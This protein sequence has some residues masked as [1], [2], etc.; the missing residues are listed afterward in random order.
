[1]TV[2]TVGPPPM[3]SQVRRRRTKTHCMRRSGGSMAPLTE[4]G[5]LFGLTSEKGTPG[6]TIILC[7]VRQHFRAPGN[8]FGQATILETPPRVRIDFRADDMLLLSDS[9]ERF[10]AM[11][12]RP[13]GEARSHE[14]I[15]LAV[16][17][18]SLCFSQMVSPPLP[19]QSCGQLCLTCLS[20]CCS[21][22]RNRADPQ[23]LRVVCFLRIGGHVEHQD[24]RGRGRPGRHTLP[25]RPPDV[26]VWEES[27]SS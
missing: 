25:C 18:W 4:N 14:W 11:P 2:T 27:A 23:A 9:G 6:T 21:N 15:I 26:A 16:P 22:V 17:S 3:L 10:H 19:A 7:G 8:D 20:R 12:G 24:G 5:L 1:M 13:Y